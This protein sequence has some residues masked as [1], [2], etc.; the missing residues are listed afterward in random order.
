MSIDRISEDPNHY[1]VYSDD[2]EFYEIIAEFQ[3]AENLAA[4]WHQVV[5]LY[6]K[7]AV[8]M[9]IIN[10]AEQKEYIG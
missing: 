8:D 6:G 1:V 3:V 10:E 4:G 5:W 7:D 9:D 2:P